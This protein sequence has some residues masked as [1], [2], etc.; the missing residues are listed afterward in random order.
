M[1]LADGVVLVVAPDG[2]AAG[3]GFAVSD[4]LLVTC[5]H[6]IQNCSAQAEGELR[7][8]SV[9]V[10]FHATGDTRE[11]RASAEAT[12]LYQWWRGCD[13]ED[14]AFLRVERLPDRVTVLPLG[15]AD[16]VEQDDVRVFGYPK[17]GQIEGLG[18]DGHVVR[19]VKESGRPLLQLSSSEITTGF[20]GA[21]LWDHHKRRVIGVVTSVSRP[22]EYGKLGETAFATPTGALQAICPELQV[23]DVCPYVSLKPFDVDNAEFFFGR[24]RL[25]DKLL[26]KLRSNPRFLALLGPSGSGKSSAIRAGLVPR[27]AA[28]ALPGSD[29]WGTVVFRPGADPF[30]ELAQTGLGTEKLA[31]S[32]RQWIAAAQ[33]KRGVLIID[34][35]EELLVTTP[36][37]IRADFIAQLAALLNSA[38]SLTVIVV[39]RNDFY[40]RLDD[41]AAAL[42]PWLEQGL[43]NILTLDQ[44]ELVEIVSEPAKR[45]GLEFEEGLVEVI[46]QEAAAM[47]AEGDAIPSTILPLVEFALTELWEQSHLA[48]KLTHEAYR[49]LG[50][51]SGALTQWA[52]GAFY[53]LDDRQR[54][55]AR[56][57]FLD[58][59]HVAGEGEQ[60]PDTR[61]RR[62]ISSLCPA[63]EDRGS[64]EAVVNQLA[65]RRLVIISQGN[66]RAATA[67]LIHDS[68]I[69]E[70]G[71][72]HQWVSQERPFRKWLQTTEGALR[73]WTDYLHGKRRGPDPD[74]L[75]GQR[76]VVAEQ[77]LHS[78]GADFSHDLREFIEASVA[79]RNQ[80]AER[81]R[82]RL[83]SELERQQALRVS[84]SLR[85]ASEARQA[86]P[87]EP[88]TAFL[89]AWEA[90]L[91]D[92][93]ELTESVFR[94]TLSRM[95]APVKILRLG[96]KHQDVTAGFAPDGN[97]V[98]AANIDT[99]DVD[100]WSLGGTL[101]NHFTVEGSGVTAAAAI[102]GHD[103]LLTWRDHILRLHLPD[104]SVLDELPLTED[105]QPESWFQDRN[106]SI[107]KSGT[108][109]VH[110][111]G[112]GWMVRIDNV[113]D[114]LRLLH[115]LMFSSDDV[116]A[117][118]HGPMRRVFRANLNHDGQTILT[119]GS[120]AAGLWISDGGL[121]AALRSDGGI[122]GA[123]FLEAGRVVTCTMRGAGNF[124][125]IDG[126]AL[127][128]FKRANGGQDLFIR[129]ISTH[130][131]R[132][133]T[134]V[135]TSGVIE[136]WTST[137][138]LV[139]TLQGHAGNIWSGAFSPDD[140]LLATGGQDCIIRVYDWRSE[141]SLFELHGHD[142]TVYQ[143][144]FHP[145]RPDLLLSTG[146]DGSVRLW[147]LDKTIL[148]SFSGHNEA[149]KNMISTPVGI[150]SSSL[151]GTSRIWRAWGASSRLPGDPVSWC[152]TSTSAVTILTEDSSGSAYLS[153]VTRSGD[154][155]Q[156][157]TV[158]AE[159]GDKALSRH[160]AVS[161]NGSQFI[162]MRDEAANLYSDCGEHLCS[163]VGENPSD[164]RHTIIGGGFRRDG[165]AIL[166]AAE[167]GAVWLW[168]SDGSPIGGFLAGYDVPLS[169]FDHH[170]SAS[171]GSPDVIKS[172]GLDPCGEYILI[173]LR[174]R[175]C[176]WTW[177]CE[178]R[179]RLWPAGYKVFQAAFTPD[180]SRVVTIAD[181]PSGTPMAYAQLW[182]RD[183][184]LIASL[185]AP[186]AVPST[187][188]YCDPQS[189]YICLAS[190]FTIRI[191]D[192]SG[193]PLGTL[194]AA[195]GIHALDVA[196]QDNGDLI[197]VL[198]SD[199]LV[200]IWELN[201]KRRSMT[202]AVAHATSIAFTSDSSRLLAGSSA[203]LI[204]Q[205]ALNI[206][207]L[208]PAAATRIDRELTAEEIDRFGV[209]EP[210]RFNLS[211]Y[212]NILW[213]ETGPAGCTTHRTGA[214]FLPLVLR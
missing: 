123:G 77:W 14:I 85:L 134:T 208:F 193:Q 73:S 78:R 192:R 172:V 187:E 130:G 191:F 7:P 199:G 66:E 1:N 28:G 133:A 105:H 173:G 19:P 20:S 160:G 145:A 211:S 81:E 94:E 22:D 209:T 194:A 119:E 155:T 99:G 207:D 38:L 139:A 163:L 69:R 206:E 135:N 62:D 148:P 24:G 15:S 67:E 186:D 202:L 195:R 154:Y 12:V 101:V 175:V 25:I 118:L 178:L 41:G 151:D 61:E 143:V 188:V 128:Q 142:S 136:V 210:V 107:T 71:P 43:L 37:S 68:L 165:D 3:T 84:E 36:A 98:F 95:P 74:W 174:E 103:M 79:V 125:G 116:R 10:V 214:R 104:G 45:V 111:G 162:L 33:H 197:A 76:L 170:R 120:D 11:T 89:I 23:S 5:S 169:F 164:G 2:S 17:V 75:R 109:L 144:A 46:T 49:A 201:G 203:G 205:Y 40:G 60:M 102:P 114:K 35:F 8:E 32:F 29:E 110:V 122:A 52:D 53:G 158:A 157:G 6:V 189:R 56:S 179:Q 100:I 54:P 30:N 141:A 117:E 26:S 18:G 90:V 63:V 180:G 72:L 152:A 65:A 212:K 150:L 87:S 121:R 86:M 108:C 91:R 106:L 88:D 13:Q 96:G 64:V 31:M 59:V 183:G 168:N 21:P 4:T 166:T 146:H 153:T 176:F 171:G 184:G 200:R 149:I 147:T 177:D 198:F 159:L 167:N 113:E 129:A 27:L 185:Y 132:F 57:I 50:G 213:A 9:S 161:P 93:N 190:A 137:G 48:G 44:S 204:D 112:R 34:Q 97:L 92:R 115:S 42:L 51:I 138:Q 39:M 127:D 47:R 196:M 126:G 55:L 156:R 16:G 124:W 181:N 83:A 82:S 70:W 182:D 80:E 131:E 58:L 140:R